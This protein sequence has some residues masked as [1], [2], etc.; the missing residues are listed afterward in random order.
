VTVRVVV[1]GDGLA[2]DWCHRCHLHPEL[3]HR[4]APLTYDEQA[5]VARHLAPWA[6]LLDLLAARF[7]RP[8][9]VG[10]AARGLDGPP[11]GA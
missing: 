10:K 4:P 5:H 8:V 9:Y 6:L 3:Y 11:A 1:G 7:G 2:L